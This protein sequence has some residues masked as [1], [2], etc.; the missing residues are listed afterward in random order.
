MAVARQGNRFDGT[1]DSQ[2]K[3]RLKRDGEAPLRMLQRRSI[4]PYR[5]SEENRGQFWTREDLRVLHQTSWSDGAIWSKPLLSDSS[6]RSY[7]IARGF[8]LASTPG[9][10]IPTPDYT[11]VTPTYSLDDDLQRPIAVDY[12]TMYQIVGGGA[13]QEVM[14]WDGPN[15]TWSKL[16]NNFGNSDLFPQAWCWHPKLETLFCLYSDGNIHY[17]TPDSAGGSVIDLAVTVYWRGNLFVHEGRL[18]AWTGDV[19][20]EIEDPLGTPASTIIYDDGNGPDAYAGFQSG[21]GDLLS[22]NV[23][24]AIPSSEGIWVTKNTWND[25]QIQA[26]VVRIDRQQDGTNVAVP[27]GSLPPDM[28]CL[29]MTYHLGS[30]LFSASPDVQRVLRNRLS[31]HGYPQIFIYGYTN[32]EGFLTIGSPTGPDPD[33]S[34]HSFVSTDGDRVLIGGRQTIWV[35]DAALGGLHQFLDV[36]DEYDSNDGYPI[37]GGVQ[38]T[39]GNDQHWWFFKRNQTQLIEFPIKDQAGDSITHELESN[40]FDFNIPGEAKE[41][42]HVTL[43]T[44]GIQS[45][46]TWSVAIKE[47]DTGGWT[48]VATF[49][50]SDDNVTRK[51]LSTLQAGYRFQYRLTYDAGASG[52]VVNP[53]NVKGITFEAHQGVMVRQWQLLIDGREFRSIEGEP[54]RPADV[55]AWLQTVAATQTV[56]AWDNEYTPDGVADSYNVKVE[57]AEVNWL[58]PNEFEAVLSLTEDI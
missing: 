45:N 56:I 26:Q 11:M 55:A 4:L 13:N 7:A 17:V 5:E 20:Y 36:S 23:R 32:K 48:T 46:E 12:E 54:V 58:T 52:D 27:V 28:I 57:G 35:Y 44:D 10:V 34:P 53:S 9:S 39:D 3:Y 42:T 15:Q 49:T 33:D 18:M 19:L 51:R 41:I 2:Y 8:D 16:T 37:A 43:Q 25:S 21:A 29:D 38:V 6:I 47:D 1:L 30:V 14:E 22:N 40:Y 31:T 50:A 24:G